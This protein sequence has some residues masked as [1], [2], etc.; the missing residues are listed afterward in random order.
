M[1]L[2]LC[3]IV[4]NL[5]APKPLRMTYDAVIAEL[6]SYSQKTFEHIFDNHGAGGRSW[7][8]KIEDLKKIQK[9]VRTDHALA[10][11]LFDTGIS[12]AQ[13][14]AGLIADEKKIT[15]EQLHHWA[16]HA[17]WSMVSEYTVPWIAAD[18][19]HGWDLALEWIDAKEESLQATGWATLASVVATRPD[20]DLDLRALKDLL[21]RVTGTIHASGN[22]VRYLM[23]SFVIALGT[24]VP[25]L[26]GEA[27]AAG[28]TIGKVKVDMGKTACKVP[29]APDYIQ[30]VIDRGTVGKK[31]KMARC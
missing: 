25:L 7:G 9:K 14:L 23:N 26:T 13:Y 19:P 12:D 4:S 10:L 27:V 2:F 6:K 16:R 31:R 8:V 24:S 11:Q 29:F 21:N 5:A 3:P 22:R 1:G 20:D 28:N 15:K 18:S 30:K 17:S